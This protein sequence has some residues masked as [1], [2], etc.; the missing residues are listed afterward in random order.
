MALLQRANWAVLSTINYP[1]LSVLSSSLPYC[2]TSL[3]PSL[4]SPHLPYFPTFPLP[5]LLSP[6]FPTSYFPPSFT[7]S[8]L[9]P[10]LP[11][12]PSLPLRYLLPY[13]GLNIFYFISH[14]KGL[15]RAK[16]LCHSPF[17]LT[18][19]RPP[20]P[21]SLLGLNIF[22]VIYMKRDWQ[23]THSTK[24]PVTTVLTYPWKCRVLHCNHLG[25]TWQPLVLMT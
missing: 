14:E 2:L 4:L 23:S 18:Y 13:L 25:N 9:S 3:L 8:L 12:F 11:Y 24:K 1:A 10:S 19:F 17:P 15:G 7:T 22:Y 20:F 21:T 6:P 16:M 5:S